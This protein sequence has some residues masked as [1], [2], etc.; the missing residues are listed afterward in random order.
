METP[1][2]AAWHIAVPYIAV[3]V[4]GMVLLAR[5]P[6]VARLGTVQGFMVML[7]LFATGTYL[8]RSGAETIGVQ[9]QA[10]RDECA[11]AP[12]GSRWEYDSATETEYL[13]APTGDGWEQWCSRYIE[14]SAWTVDEDDDGS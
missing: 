8:V 13:M 12:I 7:A 4:V 2:V 3:L 11:G 5:H 14:G 1:S 9:M 10:A 6:L